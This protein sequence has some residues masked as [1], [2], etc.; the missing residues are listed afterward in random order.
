MADDINTQEELSM[1]EILSSIKGI[2]SE[3]EQDKPSTKTS[4]PTPPS[5][6]S[7]AIQPSEDAEVFDLSASMIVDNQPPAGDSAPIAK[8][9]PASE[10][11]ALSPLPEA[12]PEVE[13]L[14]ALPDNIPDNIDVSPIEEEP[15]PAQPSPE[16]NIAA[17]DV[18]DL[19]LPKSLN[20]DSDDVLSL[21]NL[22][23]VSVE[24]LITPSDAPDDDI[25]GLSDL[26]ADD[27]G[28]DT[29]ELPLVETSAEEAASASLPEAAESQ[30]EADETPEPHE[31]HENNPE[32][33]DVSEAIIDN[34]AQMFNANRS[35]APTETAI[36]PSS[37]ATPIG[38]DSKTIADLVKEVLSDSLRPVIEQKLQSIDSDILQVLHT[39]IKSQAKAWVDANLNRVVEDAVKEEIKRVIAKV[40]S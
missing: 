11:A 33:A 23:E 26:I 28:S 22:P 27:S 5:P 1:E 15:Y 20:S 38:A 19:T 30:P 21:D 3:N 18:S 12:V 14:A 32:P 24:E 39:E 17:A 7:P 31:V 34:F 40:G 8:A 4:S 36:A 25:S 10:A 13:A 2:L 9:E 29:A 37:E 16:A 35:P 6:E